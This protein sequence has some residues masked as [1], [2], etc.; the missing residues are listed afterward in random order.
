MSFTPH[1]VEAPAP[2]PYQ[3]LRQEFNADKP[4]VLVVEDHEDTRFML[5]TMLEMIGCQ[6]MEAT[7]GLEAVEIAQREQPQLILIDG[8]LPLLDGLSAT[9]QM[10]EHSDLG[11]V[12]IVATSGHVTP[13]FHAAALAA[14]CDDCLFK[15]FGFE[16]L[17]NLVVGLFH[18]FP[19]AA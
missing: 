5:R 8:S 12:P 4:L 16:Q 10:R 17:K 6:V 7:D 19:E 2:A 11:D 1:I 13:R 14:G 15:P 3:A 9:R 18:I